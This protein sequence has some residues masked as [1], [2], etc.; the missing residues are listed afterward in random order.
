M[1]VQAAVFC[2]SLLRCAADPGSL[3]ATGL[4]VVLL[5]PYYIRFPAILQWEINLRLEW[6]DALIRFKM[7]I[8][9]AEPYKKP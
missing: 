2:R 1:Y 3:P 6:Q 9:I 5:L 8:Y 7:R 4:S